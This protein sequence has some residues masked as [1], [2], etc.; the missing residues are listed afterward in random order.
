MKMKLP[1]ALTRTFG[2]IMLK[3][4]KHGPEACVVGGLIC[5]GAAIVMVGVKTWKNKDLL[6]EDH[7]AIKEAKANV[8]KAKNGNENEDDFLGETTALVPVETRNKELTRTY[9]TFAKDIGKTYW[10]PVVL[11]IGSI[12]LIFGGTR[13]LRKQLTALG[14]AY[15][16]LMDSFKKYRDRVVEDQGVEA[17]EKYMFG[18]NITVTKDDADGNTKTAVIHQPGQNVSRYSRWWDAGDYDSQEDIWLWRN[19]EWRPDPLKNE[20]TLRRIQTTVNNQ[21]RAYGFLFLNDVYKELGLPPTKEGQ[22]VGWTTDGGDG[23][24]DFGIWPTKDN[25]HVLN[26]NKPF[27]DGTSPN[28]MLD[29][30]VDGPILYKLENTWGKET[31]QKL[32]KGEK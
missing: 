22:I 2:K 27:L 18:E 21:L 9:V 1:Q 29:F 7:K 20:A 5:G 17:D 4:K 25:P 6:V 28:V 13:S 8:E 23:Y 3:A 12:G 10:L 19:M 30:N 15:A 26:V 16:M 31:A 24:I 14:G 11:E 32:I